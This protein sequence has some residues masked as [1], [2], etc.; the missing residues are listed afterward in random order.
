VL[1]VDIKTMS[2]ERMLMITLSILLLTLSVLAIRFGSDRFPG[3][4]A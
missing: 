2:D 3:K 1:A 4:D